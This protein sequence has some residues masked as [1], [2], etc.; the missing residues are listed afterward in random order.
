MVE[1]GSAIA[2]AQS[3]AATTELGALAL[4]TAAA[5]P[6]LVS[7]AAV[8]AA[9]GVGYGVHKAVSSRLKGA[10]PR[11][12]QPFWVATHK[13]GEVTIK[14]FVCRTAAHIAFDKEHPF[15][16]I[17]LELGPSSI[18]NGKTRPW[19]EFRHDGPAPWVDDG[20]RDLIQELCTP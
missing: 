5:V 18:I 20:M 1:A 17:A 10:A 15:R 12:D 3:I 14:S 8:A 9:A 6:V 7:V 4:G 11:L 13:W 19:R 2:I 16:R